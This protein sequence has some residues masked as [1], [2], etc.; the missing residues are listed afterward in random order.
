MRDGWLQVGYYGHGSYNHGCGIGAGNS[1]N[2]PA[3]TVLDVGHIVFKGGY[4]SV[5][6]AR[7]GG[8]AIG[9]G[10][11]TA[12]NSSGGGLIEF[13]GGTVYAKGARKDSDAAVIGGGKQGGYGPTVVLDVAATLVVQKGDTK[14]AWGI[15]GV[16]DI[17]AGHEGS[18]VI[19]NSTGVAESRV[20]FR[21][22]FG[23]ELAGANESGLAVVDARGAAGPG[24]PQLSGKVAT[25]VFSPE[26][27]KI[28]LS[29]ASGDGAFYSVSGSAVTV[30]AAAA[31]K[32]LS[33][34]GSG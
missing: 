31:G 5:C 21:S 4:T 28:N 1:Y 27:T 14:C 33:V 32:T 22:E 30:K 25:S 15:G 8:A 26:A 17:A 18:L 9:G 24:A 10:H 34:T 13:L 11:S 29:T 6:G 2:R 7:D 23:D 20:F 3:G 19:T 12:G 16:G